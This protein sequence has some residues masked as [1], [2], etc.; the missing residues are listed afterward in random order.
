MKS[1]DAIVVLDVLRMGFTQDYFIYFPA[2]GA[3]TQLLYPLPDD[4]QEQALRSP[5]LIFIGMDFPGE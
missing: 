2:G 1:R 5:N 3:A 4:Q